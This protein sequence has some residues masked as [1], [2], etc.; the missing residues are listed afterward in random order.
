MS[1]GYFLYDTLAMAYYGLLDRAMCFHH[2]IVC[3]GIYLSLCFGASGS[4]ILAGIFISEV[5]NPVM[6]FRLIIRSIGLRH[7]KAY[8]YSELLY[9]ILYIYNR[10]FKGLFIVY[11]TVATPV[12]HPIIKLISVGVAVQS[13]F[14]VVKMVS[15]LKNRWTEMSEREKEKVTLFWLAHNPQVQKLSYYIRSA[16]KEGI[17]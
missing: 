5:S 16:K 7:T 14:Y 12:G 10:L 2:S 3:L 15:I 4:E 9:I 13:Y 11:G 6:H 1:L 17:P 8:E